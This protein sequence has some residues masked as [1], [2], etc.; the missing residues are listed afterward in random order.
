MKYVN[1]SNEWMLQL[2]AQEGV[3]VGRV[4][5]VEYRK[6]VEKQRKSQL[7]AKP[8]HGRFLKSTKVDEKGEIIAGPRSWEWVKSGYMTKSTE[9]FLFA[10][11]EQ[12][13]RTNA[14]RGKIY[15]EVDEDGIVVSGMCKLCKKK[16]ETVAHIIGCCPV[17]TEGPITARHDKMGSRIHWELC[18]KYGVEC[19]VRWYEHKPQAVS[20]DAKGEIIIYWDQHIPTAV[21]VGCDKPDVVVAN[22]KT[23]TWTIID[24]AVPLDHNI[25]LKECEK[26]GKYQKLAQ[27]VRK[28][29]KVKTEIIP[30]VVGALGMIPTRLPE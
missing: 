29:Y 19:S 4:E 13:L 27:E 23:K 15:R 12:A 9:A 18:R 20:R 7:L 8:L 25:V 1:G 24:F 22:T 26:V 16:T 2:V 17:L 3:V 21:P 14:V 10:A 30:I 6:R 5:T 28:T 11:Q